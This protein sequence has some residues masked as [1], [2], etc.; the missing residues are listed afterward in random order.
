MIVIGFLILR[1][2]DADWSGMRWNWRRK[3]GR[4][5]SGLHRAVGYPGGSVA[6][7]AIVGYT[8]DFLRLDGGFMVMI[9]GSILAVILLIIVMIGEKRRHQNY[10]KNAMEANGMN[11][12][13]T[14]AWRS[15]DVGQFGAVSLQQRRIDK[16]VIAHRGASYLG[17]LSSTRCQKRW[18]TG[19]GL[20]GTRFGDDHD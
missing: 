12:A 11:D 19:S 13:K 4:Y 16:M 3:S 20:S 14:L 5:G 1:P 9:G 15:H 8:V 17:Y 10:C 18:R 7:S 2:G 6:A